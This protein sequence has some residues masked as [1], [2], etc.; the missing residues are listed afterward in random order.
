MSTVDEPGV[1]MTS[2]DGEAEDSALRALRDDQAKL[3]D[4]EQ[5]KRVLKKY[6]FLERLTTSKNEV[7]PRI[8]PA[9]PRSVTRRWYVCASDAIKTPEGSTLETLGL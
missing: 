3:D 5:R 2:E 8:S 4:E 9:E 6:P 1:A 7:E